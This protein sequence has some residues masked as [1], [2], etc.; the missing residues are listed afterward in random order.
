MVV[1]DVAIGLLVLL[2]SVFVICFIAGMVGG[3]RQNNREELKNEIISQIEENQDT[4][5]EKHYCQMCGKVFE[6]PKEDSKK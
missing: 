2:A 3:I 5:T 1:E 4:E 6:L